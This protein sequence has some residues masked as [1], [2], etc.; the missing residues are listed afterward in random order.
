MDNDYFLESEYD[1][2]Y[3]LD[4]IVT[5]CDPVE[6]EEFDIGSEFDSKVEVI[7]GL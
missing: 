2:D 1:F 4:Y 6:Y 3:Q 5:G 7:H